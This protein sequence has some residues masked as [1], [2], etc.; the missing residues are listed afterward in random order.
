MRLVLRSEVA[1]PLRR[2]AQAGL[3]LCLAALL[4]LSGAVPRSAWADRDSGPRRAGI[5][6]G[7]DLLGERP[8][9]P[10]AW[11]AVW[12]SQAANRE[13]AF[14]GVARTTALIDE[15]ERTAMAHVAGS[16]GKVRFD[17]ETATRR[18]SLVDDGQ[19]LVHLNS[20]KQE[21]RVTSRPAFSED[22]RLAERNYDAKVV[23][24]AT[25][26]GRPCDIVQVSP[27]GRGGPARRSLGGGGTVWRLWLDRQ[28]SF[29][30]K[31][32]RYNIEGILTSGTEYREITFGTAV[33]P[34]LF[35][36]PSG[37]KVVDRDGSGVRLEITEL[38]RRVGFSLRTPRYLPPGYVF[39]GGY[40]QRRRHGNGR[41]ESAPHPGLEMGEL[42]YTDGLRVLSIFQRQREA[43]PEPGRRGRGED[44]R[45]EERGEHRFRRGRGGEQD[46]DRG[47][48]GGR[49]SGG[50]R[51]GRGPG[52]EFG[53]AESE[54]MTVVARGSEKVLRY[55]T[56]DRII[57][58]VGDLPAEEL[59]RVARS[60]Q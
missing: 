28:T 51:G 49:G 39:L 48:R 2:V 10:T 34:E 19:R 7:A 21:A 36:I 12:K 53:P 29:A 6:T 59:T 20:E 32:E 56:K 54:G 58:V 3:L 15:K 55:P 57:I 47:G 18:W 46:A 35:G 17:Y 22:R 8:G 40:V 14:T 44:L 50:G 25:V 52:H 42:R 1:S 16:G 43:G 33:S 23:G 60:L 38:E 26:A 13:L 27:R 5:A 45:G 11:E 31:R 24:G 37:W 4:S 41:A 9:K 30:L